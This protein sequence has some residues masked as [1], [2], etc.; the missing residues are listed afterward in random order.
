MELEQDSNSV[1]TGEQVLEMDATPPAT[2]SQ[3]IHVQ[4]YLLTLVLPLV[5]MVSVLV[6]N[7]VM[8]IMQQQEMVVMQAV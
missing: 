4:E 2:L 8:T 7:N 5:K 3:A 6:L 1:T